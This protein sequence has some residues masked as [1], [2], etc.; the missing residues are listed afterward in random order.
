M[1]TWA[2][3]LNARVIRRCDDRPIEV[4]ASTGAEGVARGERVR[5][6][7]RAAERPPWVERGSERR[8]E[9]DPAR[10]SALV[11]ERKREIDMRVLAVHRRNEQRR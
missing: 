6:T 3:R 5:F 10:S 4:R 9:H 1:R 8:V 11:R 2:A 7:D